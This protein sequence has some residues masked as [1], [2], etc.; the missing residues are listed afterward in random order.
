MDW[1]DL[2]T[3]YILGAFRDMEEMV[4]AKQQI[5]AEGREVVYAKHRA[6]VQEQDAQWWVLASLDEPE[7]FLDYT[8]SSL[9]HSCRTAGESLDSAIALLYG[10]RQVKHRCLVIVKL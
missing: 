3:G 6:N 5:E 1:I 10:R 2:Q 7:R 4:L 9:R 8:F